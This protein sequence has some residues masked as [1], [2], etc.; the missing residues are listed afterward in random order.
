MLRNALE[1]NVHLLTKFISACSSTA[2]FIGL[3]NPLAGIQYAR[4]VFDQRHHRDD[5]FLCNS[6]IKA[7]VDKHQFR[8]SMTLYRG[9]RSETCFAPDDYTF[10][11]LVKYSGFNVAIKEGQQLHNQVIKMGF[12]SDLFVST[13]LVDMYAKFGKMVL[14]RKVFDEMIHRSPV[15]WTALVVG[16]A[17]SG[18]MG[19]ARSFFTRMPEK[20]PAAFN[21]MVDAFVKSGNVDSARELF[22]EMPE[23]NV[24]SWTTL[25]SGYCKNGYVGA[26]RSLFDAMP[27]KNLVSWNA[28]IAGYCQNKQPH[29]AL[30]LFREM[31]SSFQPDEVS[32][33]SILPAIADLGALDLGGWVHRYV[34]R[35]KFDKTSNI[36]TALVD[37]YAKC[38]EILK[39]KQFFD[40]MQEIEIGSWNAMINGFA[41][42]G[43]AKEA[44]ELF[45][46][47]QNRGVKPNEVTM[48][49]VLSAC[50][51]SGLVEEGRKW[52][53]AMEG[54]GL[55]Q[56]I[57]HYGC[58]V[59]ILGR[60]GCLQDAE[61]LIE[62]MP[63]EVNG[64]ILSSFLFACGC[65]GDVTRAERV[66][67]NLLKM[68][69]QEDGNYVMLRNLYAGERR[70]RDVEEVKELMRRNGAKKEH[71]SGKN[72]GT[73]KSY[74]L[75]SKNCNHFTDGNCTRLTGK[76]TLS[77][78]CKATAL[79]SCSLVLGDKSLPF[80]GY[81]KIT[82]RGNMLI[83]ASFVLLCKFGPNSQEFSFPACREI[84][85]GTWDSWVMPL[86][87]QA[88]IV[89]DKVKEMKELS[90]GYNIVGLSQSISFS[91]SDLL[92]SSD[93]K[94]KNFISLG[95]PHAGT[96]SV[97]LCGS[98][99]I[100]II[101]DI[102]IKSGIYS[103]YVQAHLAP[104]GYLKIPTDIPAYLEGCRFL[105]RLNNEL[106]GKRNIT[107]K[108]R[109]SSLQNL[110]LIMFEQ[111]TVLIPKETAWFGFY[112]DG[113]FKPVLPPQQTM[114]YIED[115]IGLKTLDDAG[116][117]K[118]ISVEGNHLGISQTDMIKHIV[119]YLL[120]Q[121]SKKIMIGGSSSYRLP[122]S[123][124]SFI[125]ELVGLVK[126]S[127]LLHT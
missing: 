71:L 81:E 12:C 113:A 52:F 66:M 26:A 95:G 2:V 87:E 102:L 49:G 1:T 98:G 105:P 30:E 59:D 6:M 40:Q 60:A 10:S 76:S 5:T 33:V 8:E 16:Y 17:R 123:I 3:S 118:Y 73:R 37:M 50:N 115:W 13:A 65:R 32:I 79:C 14:S 41:I 45:S 112:S 38:G 124:W 23:K 67:K 104:S 92:S 9:L 100:C 51:H 18:D 56:R 99:F 97:P 89:C 70:W 68:V 125:G 29:E 28:M 103:D 11:S 58:M 77:P 80:Y 94:V 117:V 53:K 48:I 4:C 96:A 69:P 82:D 101:V 127:P 57:E 121:A 106:P 35:K 43:C 63:Y 42:N 20:D 107:Y 55:T 72:M 46:E 119:P 7:H 47:M 122:S 111:D 78:R 15:T 83:L 110:V 90:E 108:E 34:R 85:D 24:I 62:N 19:A 126:D 84:G 21:A 61:Q 74:R 109:F 39:A 75:I 86:Q 22:D 36:C 114:L 93:A 64:I 25:I 27:D 54:Y 91:S 116:S 120:D 44:L 88:G 31:Q